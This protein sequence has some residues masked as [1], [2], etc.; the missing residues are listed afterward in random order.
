MVLENRPVRQIASR[1]DLKGYTASQVASKWRISGSILSLDISRNAILHI[2]VPFM[3]RRPQ[4]GC[5]IPG[6]VYYGD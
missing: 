5:I 2:S 6:L 1:L 3:L 4:C